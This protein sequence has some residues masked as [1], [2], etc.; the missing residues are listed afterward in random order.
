MGFV[1]IWHIPITILIILFII[2]KI[3]FDKYYTKFKYTTRNIRNSSISNPK[4]KNVNVQ[5]SSH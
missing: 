3:I 2:I 4:N 5:M 1:I